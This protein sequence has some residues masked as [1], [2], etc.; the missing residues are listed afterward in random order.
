MFSVIHVRDY[1]LTLVKAAD[2]SS[3]GLCGMV[4]GGKMNYMSRFIQSAYIT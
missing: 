2:A 3:H 1:L 4:H